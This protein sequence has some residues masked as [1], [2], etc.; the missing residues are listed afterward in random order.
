MSEDLFKKPEE[1]VPAG[2]RKGPDL[3]GVPKEFIQAY[4]YAIFKCRE[5]NPG[6]AFTL[7]GFHAMLDKW[8]KEQEKKIEEFIK[9]GPNAKEGDTFVWG[10]RAAAST[11]KKLGPVT[12]QLT[13]V[14]E[15]KEQVS[16]MKDGDTFVWGT[17]VWRGSRKDFE[18][19]LNAMSDGDSLVWGT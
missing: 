12:L 1:K 6:R 18:T 17:R 19:Q 7:D 11:E 3:S 14:A 4:N 16:T 8:S 10:T 13:T 15:A 5:G 9:R 2:M